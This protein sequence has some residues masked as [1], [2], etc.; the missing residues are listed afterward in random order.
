MYMKC[1]FHYDRKN[2]KFELDFTG[3]DSIE[4]VYVAGRAFEELTGTRKLTVTIE[5][6]LSR[7]IAAYLSNRDISSTESEPVFF[8]SEPDVGT[9]K[10]GLAVDSELVAAYEYHRDQ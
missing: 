8:L 1:N 7:A 10:N 2:D 4:K 5:G 9:V 6:D 3:L